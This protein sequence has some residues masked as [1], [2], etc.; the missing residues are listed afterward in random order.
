MRCGYSPVAPG[1]IATVVTYLE[2]TRRPPDRP[3]SA[4]RSDLDLKRVDGTSLDAYRACFRRVGEDWLWFSRLVM[5]D[6]ELRRILD[7]PQ[8]MALILRRG[9]RPIG[10]LEMDF[11]QAG[12][13][14]LAFFGLAAEAIGK[15]IGRVLMDR[16]VALAWAQPIRR[17]WVHTCGFDHPSAVGF[18]CRSGFRPYAFAVEVLEDPRLTGL[19]AHTRA[20][21]VPLI[22][23]DPAS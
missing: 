8:V 20:P 12:E 18:Y 6:G 21:H 10:L 7:D 4:R 3:A 11:R 14:E 15:G 17:F 13:C 16:A 5:P 1:Q 22:G 23:G 2:M 9:S 19:I